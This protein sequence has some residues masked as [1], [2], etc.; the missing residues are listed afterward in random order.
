MVRRSAR[1]TAIT[2][3]IFDMDGVLA[4]LDKDKRLEWLSRTTGKIPEHFN[5]TV[6]HSDFER[7][8]EAGEY[9]TASAYLAEF[10][11]RTGCALSREQWIEA[12]RQAM[13]LIPETLEIARKLRQVAGIAMLTNNGSL[14]KENLPELM[15]ELCG[16]FGK[17]LHASCE[18]NA[19]KPD[20]MVF[21]R[22]LAHYSVA[23]EQ[24][25]L[26]D[27]D[28]LNVRGARQAGLCALLFQDPAKLHMELSWLGLLPA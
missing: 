27:D 17:A 11:R 22:L 3:V 23:H 20:K 6:W 18:F 10:N 14:L 5:S 4:H 15:P 16:V 21:D 24:A 9:P 2:F 26:I 25:L 7:S 12:R 1:H 13:T 8:A 28:P 19:R